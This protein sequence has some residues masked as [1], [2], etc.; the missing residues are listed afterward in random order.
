MSDTTFDKKPAFFRVMSAE[1]FFEADVE[2]T[3]D[4]QLDEAV[5]KEI[6]DLIA[7][8]AQPIRSESAQPIR[9]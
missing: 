8:L 1:M 2:V 3:E 4:I 9:K 5:E 7:E 6:D